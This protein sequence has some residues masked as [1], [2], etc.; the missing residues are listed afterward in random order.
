MI[1]IPVAVK[2]FWRR[3][4]ILF[5]HF[6]LL[7]LALYGSYIF[8]KANDPRIGVEGFGDLFGYALNAVGLSIAIFT[9]WWF[10]NNAWHDLSA[11]TEEELFAE[12]RKGDRWSFW[13]RVQDRIEW[14]F[15]VVFFCYIIFR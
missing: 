1:N 9:S 11:H 3:N 15:L 14:A 2:E 4:Q 13:L 8:I 10:K 5:L 12:A 7:L 6:P